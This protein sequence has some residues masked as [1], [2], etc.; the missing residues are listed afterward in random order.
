MSI[1]NVKESVCLGGKQTAQTGNERATRDALTKA[2]LGDHLLDLKFKF[3]CFH[4]LFRAV[5]A[6]Q[7]VPSRYPAVWHH[8]HSCRN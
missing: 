6:Q 4:I 7:D 2:D 1:A 5:L 8:S 3:E